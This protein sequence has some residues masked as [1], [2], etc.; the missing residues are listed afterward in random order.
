MK[1][2]E[3]LTEGGVSGASREGEANAEA[4]PPSGVLPGPP[5]QA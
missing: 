5:L 3:G 1:L 4:G 2:G